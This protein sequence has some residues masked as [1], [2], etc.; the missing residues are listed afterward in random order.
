MQH[1]V[2]SGQLLTAPS[3]EGSKIFAV[4]TLSVDRARS[5]VLIMAVKA[6]RGKSVINGIE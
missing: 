2:L 6:N 1:D 5:P 3:F 4:G